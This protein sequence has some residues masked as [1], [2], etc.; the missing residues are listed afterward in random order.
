ML[1]ILKIN[2]SKCHLCDFLK[3][4]SKNVITFHSNY[5]SRA[6]VLKKIRDSKKLEKFIIILKN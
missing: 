2:I 3:N 6:I 1:L 5:F 4:Y